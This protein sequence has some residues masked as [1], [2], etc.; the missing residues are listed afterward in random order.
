MKESYSDEAIELSDITS[1]TLENLISFCYTKSL[2]T[3]CSSFD[4]GRTLLRAADRFEC[5]ALKL[6]IESKL[7]NSFLQAINAAEC[8]LLAKSHSC[9][10]LEEAAIGMVKLMPDEVCATTAWAT[11]EQDGKLMTKILMAT[12]DPPTPTI[13]KLR[14]EL[15]SNGLD[16][17]GSRETLV[18]RLRR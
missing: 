6:F 14:K 15:S 5:I 8:L 12:I 9:A 2:A 1:S 3:E 17:D 13:A 16:I 7:V 18:K 4:E 11:V 10:L